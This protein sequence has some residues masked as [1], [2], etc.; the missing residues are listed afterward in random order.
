MRI[1]IILLTMAMLLLLIN[2][3]Y[4]DEL[5]NDENY[6]DKVREEYRSSCFYFK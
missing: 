1:I 5:A 6:C 2:I 4:R 3:E